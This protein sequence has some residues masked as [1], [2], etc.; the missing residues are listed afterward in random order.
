MVHKYVF[1]GWIAGFVSSIQVHELQSTEHRVWGMVNAMA[2]YEV[3]Y[4]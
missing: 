1:S 4:V 2:I 3:Q